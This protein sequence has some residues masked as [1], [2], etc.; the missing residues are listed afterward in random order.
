M[1][2]VLPYHSLLAMKLRLFDLMKLETEHVKTTGT[3]RK[4][5]AILLNIKI[6]RP[7][8]V[9][10]CGYKLAIHWQNFMKIYLA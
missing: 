4:I 6:N 9:N 3:P 10:M 5:N 2:W 7:K 8:L 1:N